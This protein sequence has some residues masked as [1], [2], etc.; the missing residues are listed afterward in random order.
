MLGK[1]DQ[2]SALRAQA[3]KLE[4]QLSTKLDEYEELR[5]RSAAGN[6]A[7][8]NVA[9]QNE[10]L[11][12]DIQ[13][14]M[15]KLKEIVDQMA[16]VADRD[17]FGSR[18]QKSQNVKRLTDILTERRQQY[19]RAKATI[20]SNIQRAELFG[21]GGRRKNSGDLTSRAKSE[22]LLREQT[23]L[24]MSLKATDEVISTAQASHEELRKQGTLFS[25][26]KNK[27]LQMIDMG[28]MIS[29]VIGKIRRAKQRD[30]I[31]LGLTI[32]ICMTFTFIY[33]WN[34]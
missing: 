11:S 18:D 19:S 8:A 9:Q 22:T 4:E 20:A 12:G 3:R 30:M 15:E 27:T 14:L 31:V 21:S 6:S 33:W 1:D 2:W 23:S 10:Q 13:Y 25:S 29:N 7:A 24:H 34:K 5:Q 17:R 32:G 28:P 26:T 16:E